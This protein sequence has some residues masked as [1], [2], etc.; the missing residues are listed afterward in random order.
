MAKESGYSLITCD[1]CG[2]SAFLRDGDTAM[3]DYTDVLYMRQG[4][5]A[6]VQFTLDSRCYQLWLTQQSRRDYQFDQWL[7]S[8]A[9]SKQTAANKAAADRVAK[10]EAANSGTATASLVSG[11][12]RA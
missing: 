3:S 2:A 11:D 7:A 4:A 8:G 10:Y 5:S 6:P 12:T 1:R 9:K